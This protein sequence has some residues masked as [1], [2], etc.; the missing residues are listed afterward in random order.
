M[1][2]IGDDVNG[3]AVLKLELARQFEMKDLGSLRYFLGIKVAFSPKGYL[4]SQSKYTTG[5]LERACLID[6][7]MV[8]TSLELNVQYS[9][10]DVTPLLDPTLY[11]TI[12][13]SLAYLTITRLDIAYDVHIVSQFVTSPTSV[14]WAAVLRILRYI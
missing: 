2:I 14:H 1:I 10:S 13:G 6:S 11:C 12:V 7:R 3:I 4:L 8:D 5:F 9:P